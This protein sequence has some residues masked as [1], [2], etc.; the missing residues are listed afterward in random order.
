MTEEDF[1]IKLDE[2][3]KKKKKCSLSKF[4]AIYEQK[5]TA[6]QNACDP[7][8]IKDEDDNVISETYFWVSD[9]NDEYVFVEKNV[10]SDTDHEH[11]YGRFTYTFDETNITATL[12]S[13]F[14][15]MVLTWLTV[16]ENA[17]LETSRNAFENLQ[18]EFDTY[19]SE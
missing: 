8:I 7:I 3:A 13:E 16:E 4:S 6:L 12:T 11:T 17:K 2:F 1:K 9:F 10:W 18:S 19:K 14:E 5:R 15:L